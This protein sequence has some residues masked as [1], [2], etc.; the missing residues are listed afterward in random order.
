MAMGHS[1]S[2]H[3]CL[4]LPAA[5]SFKDVAWRPAVDIYRTPTGWL[6]KFELAGVRPED[7]EVQLQGQTLL[8]GGARRDCLLEEGF[9]YHA[10]EITYSAFE[11]RVEFPV[12]LEQAE[13]R[14]E[15]RDGM[16]IVRI[17]L[18]EERP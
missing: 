13:V 3:R 7:F 10:L 4:F 18:E 9:R 16:L 14:T 8:L 5:G 12:M 6:A 2:D 15:Y 1:R 11:R 17:Q